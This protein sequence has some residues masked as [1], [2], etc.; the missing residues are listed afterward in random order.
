[1]KLLPASYTNPDPAT[2]L[3]TAY[4]KTAI[5]KWRSARGSL[6]TAIRMIGAS[7]SQMTW[8]EIFDGN[9]Y[10]IMHTII[11][12]HNC[13]HSEGARAGCSLKKGKLGSD[14]NHGGSAP[15]APGPGQQSLAG[16]ALGSA[17][18]KQR[19]NNK[20]NPG[21]N[22]ETQTLQPQGRKPTYKTARAGIRVGRE[23]LFLRDSH[24]NHPAAL[25]HQ[26]LSHAGWNSTA[27]NTVTRS[28]TGQRNMYV[29]S[30]FRWIN[31]F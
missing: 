3:L 15:T 21:S 18:T 27:E 26:V 7:S 16:T 11:L 25:E 13:T 28:N 12:N 23:G 19:Q 14:G 2:C 10:K 9:K 4:S 29:Q 30:R 5:Q 24:W 17:S 1:M 31:V 20:P 8:K 6:L 22:Q